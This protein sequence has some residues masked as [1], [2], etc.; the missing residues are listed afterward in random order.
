MD[1]AKQ[2][3][4]QAQKK[5]EDT[6]KQFNENQTQKAGPGT[7]GTVRYDDHGRP[8]SD[9]PPADQVPAPPVA[10]ASPDPA[11]APEVAQPQ[12]PAAG[13]PAGEHPPA[14]DPAA[15]PGVAQPQPPDAEQP[16]ADEPAPPKKGMN[17]SPDPFKPL[18]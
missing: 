17:A 3:A 4:N 6:Q 14:A 5:I 11:S 13:N 12:P 8:I 16:I 18:Q 7:P 10:P 15:A 2:M 9:A 1:K